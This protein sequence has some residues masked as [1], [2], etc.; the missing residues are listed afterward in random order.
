[1]KTDP[2]NDGTIIIHS[3]GVG[4][5][6]RK[7][8]RDRAGEIAAIDGR[9]DKDIT[10]ADWELAKRELTGNPDLDPKQN[11]LDLAPEAERWDPLPGSQGTEAPTDFADGEDEEGRSIGEIL[12]DEGVS[13]ADHD[14]KLQAAREEDQP[15]E[16]K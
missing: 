15:P 4:T 9:L 8:V 12:I 7:M 5:V 2:Q 3:S 6:T 14:Q 16:D 13:E 1:M 10:K 11:I